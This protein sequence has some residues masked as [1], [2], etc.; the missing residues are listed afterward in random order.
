MQAPP[1]EADRRTLGS[2]PLERDGVFPVGQQGAKGGDQQQGLVEHDVMAGQRNFDDRGDSSELFVHVGGDVGG[3]QAVL[4]PE[5]G[6]AAR[7]AGQQVIS[8]RSV[9]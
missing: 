7:D 8:G 4:G 5:E 6:D 2:I 1:G 9:G 3:D